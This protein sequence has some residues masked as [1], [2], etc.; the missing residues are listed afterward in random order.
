MDWKVAQ[1]VDFLIVSQ[2]IVLEGVFISSAQR[3]RA[4]RSPQTGKTFTRFCLFF[5]TL[6]PLLFS[7]P[8]PFYLCAQ[9]EPIL[10]PLPTVLCKKKKKSLCGRL[11]ELMRNGAFI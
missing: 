3:L 5:L 10:I 11:S 4:I 6:Q 9:A 7:P 8:P 2:W 1:T